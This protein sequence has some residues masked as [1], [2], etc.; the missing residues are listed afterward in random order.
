MSE[1]QPQQ[2]PAWQTL[3]G[4][5][6]GMRQQRIIDL[7]AAKDRVKKYSIEVPGIFLDYSKHLVDDQILAALLQLAQEANVPGETARPIP[8]QGGEP[9]G[10]SACL[11]SGNAAP[12][13]AAQ[14]KHPSRDR[15]PEGPAGTHQH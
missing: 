12:I 5:V 2:S 10:S 1:Y 3:S 9:H 13:N 15:R 8:W 11:A 4:L 7:F 14:Y 6:Q